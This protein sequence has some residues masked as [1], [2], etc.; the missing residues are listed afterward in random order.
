[1]EMARS[2][3]VGR[4]T[5]SPTLRRTHVVSQVCQRAWCQSSL[6][7]SISPLAKPRCSLPL[8][9]L[10]ACSPGPESVRW[11][12]CSSVVPALR[13]SITGTL[14]RSTVLSTASGLT[15]PG[16]LRSGSASPRIRLAS[17]AR[18]SSGRAA[19]VLRAAACPAEMQLSRSVAAPVGQTPQSE[20]LG[21]QDVQP[22]DP[23]GR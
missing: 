5:T 8:P 12:W 3:T 15:S 1:M 14:G 13:H 21:R 22:Y 10:V 17:A 23:C 11:R 6:D 19:V 4:K 20:L 7:V 16:R 18:Q 9:W 2:R